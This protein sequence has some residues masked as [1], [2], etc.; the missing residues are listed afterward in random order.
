[1]RTRTL[2]VCLLLLSFF[3]ACSNKSSDQATTTPPA[4]PQQDQAATTP[5]ATEPAPATATPAPENTPAAEPAAV[6]EPE[7]PA[8]P[9]PVVVPA[10]TNITVRTQQ[11]LSSNKS[12]TGDS[13]M[14]TTDSSISVHGKT[15]IPAGS[16]VHGTV[17]EAKAK[18]K[19]KGEARLQLAL[20]SI[21]IKG[22]EYPIETTM[23]GFTEKG[24]GKRTAA[25]TGGGAAL[26]AIIGGIAGGG[27]G[28][29]IG[30]AVGGGAGFVGGTMT[31]NKQIDLPAETALTFK[32]NNSITLK[33]TE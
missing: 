6:K 22:N 29:A 32:L 31:G 3:V 26:G 25:T 24:K 23:T 28:A 7:K 20:T 12:Q 13:F 11:A 30:A 15:A 18:G 33:Q 1:M 17:V 10:G 14:A 16:Q 5:P 9:P 4:N 2:L 27:K 21:T 19:I 8:P